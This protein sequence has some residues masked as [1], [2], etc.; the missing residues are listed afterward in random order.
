E[1][2]RHAGHAA[3]GAQLDGAAVDAGRVAA[4]DVDVEP[5]GLV[6][7]RGDVDRQ[8]APPGHGALRHQ[9]DRLPPGGVGR[10]LR[11]VRIV[12]PAGVAWT[13]AASPGAWSR[14]GSRTSRPAMPASPAST[15]TWKETI[16]LRAA[17]RRATPSSQTAFPLLPGCERSS[18]STFSPSVTAQA[19]AT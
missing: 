14:R 1:L 7:P 2:D 6:L 19:A 9:L 16:S 8:A 18:R 4:R 17:S 11:A 15:T 12:D 13:A 5:E 10:R 3:A